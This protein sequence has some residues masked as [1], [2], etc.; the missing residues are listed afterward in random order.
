MSIAFGAVTLIL[1]FF[2]NDINELLTGEVTAVERPPSETLA[3]QR[4]EAEAK[5]ENVKEVV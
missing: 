1:A 5:G 3:V 2:L 4:A